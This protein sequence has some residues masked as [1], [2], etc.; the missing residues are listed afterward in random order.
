[1]TSDKLTTAEQAWLGEV[2]MR[3]RLGRVA[4]RESQ[5]ELAARSGASRVT[6]G[7]FERADHQAG[8]IAYTRLARALAIPNRRPA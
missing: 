1:M 8:V 4:A 5:D 3:A 7:G 6:V 2:G